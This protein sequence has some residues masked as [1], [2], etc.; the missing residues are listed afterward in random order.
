MAA[1]AGLGAAIGLGTAIYGGIAAGK[2][3]KGI[4]RQMANRPGLS[5]P[6]ALSKMVA[7]AESREGMG[8]SD[9]AKN[10]AQ[11]SAA[12]GMS[13]GASA[14]TKAGRGAL[15]SGVTS[16]V[17]GQQDAANQMALQDE[18]ARQRNLGAAQQARGM[19]AQNQTAI[20][21]DRQDAYQE[22]LSFMNQRYNQ[23][24]GL[25]SQGLGIAASS[26]AKMEK[27]PFS[28]LFKKPEVNV[29][30]FIKKVQNIAGPINTINPLLI[31]RN[32]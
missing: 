2:V 11:T 5:T 18:A 28:G 20:Q 15:A 17:R 30:D 27:N 22:K 23:M 19:M 12:Q 4:E 32:Q 8:I 24:Q 3:R 29:G 16:L 7:T 9:A 26:A 21:R 25:A 13:T 6:A 1:G 14:L 31:P 10:L